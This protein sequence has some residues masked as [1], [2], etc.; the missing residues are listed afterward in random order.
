[1]YSHNLSKVPVKTSAEIIEL[2]VGVINFQSQKVM[3]FS[4]VFDSKLIIQAMLDMVHF[5]VI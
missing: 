5:L 3:S 4:K 2:P 1:M